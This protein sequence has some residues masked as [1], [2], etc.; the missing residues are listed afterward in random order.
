MLTCR[1]PCNLDLLLY[2]CSRS[3][4]H[5][6][7]EQFIWS[8]LAA[9]A[10]IAFMHRAFQV[11][12]FCSASM[13]S[14]NK[15]HCGV[16]RVMGDLQHVIAD[17]RS[18][19]STSQ[20]LHQKKDHYKNSS[21]LIPVYNPICGDCQDLVLIIVYTTYTIYDQFDCGRKQTDSEGVK[22]TRYAPCTYLPAFHKVPVESP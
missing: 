16:A 10:L 9:Y 2:E 14:W 3:L 20:S 15:E 18:L 17:S 13:D 4:T 8:T 19:T 22:R 5:W 6:I 11:G 12:G 7:P 1:E 21:I